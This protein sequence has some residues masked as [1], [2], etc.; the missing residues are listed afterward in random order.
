LN[1][2]DILPKKLTSSLKTIR[3]K[4]KPKRLENS[5]KKSGLKRLKK[6]KPRHLAANA[7]IARTEFKVAAQ[8]AGVPADRLDAAIKLADLSDLTP[9]E[10]TGEIPPAKLK[11]AVEAT[12]KANPFLKG[13][14]GSGGGN[15]GP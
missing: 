8:A 15:V 7:R 6:K 3:Q 13:T 11:S 9:D 2:K 12:L 10:K 4:R 1:S 5:G 14:G